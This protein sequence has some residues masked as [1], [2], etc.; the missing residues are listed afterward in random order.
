MVFLVMRHPQRVHVVVSDALTGEAIAGA[1]V[2][3]NERVFY[4]DGTGSLNLGWVY[5]TH[6]ITVHLDGYLPLQ[7]EIPKGR[8]PTQGLSLVIPLMPNAL[9]GIV[10]DAETGMPLE[11]S[12]VTAGQL[13]TTTDEHGCYTLHRIKTG[14]PLS[15]SMPGYESSTA[16]FNGQKVQDFSLRPT[17]TRVEVLDLYSGRPVSDAVVSW[18]SIQ[19]TT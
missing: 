10:S 14:V 2:Q 11:G 9:S 17:E 4:T 6:A 8:V 18:S 5:N 12:V 13:A 3:T 7:V 19:S 15:A 16:V 1:V